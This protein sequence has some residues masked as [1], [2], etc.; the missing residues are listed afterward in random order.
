MNASVLD[1]HRDLL[2][3]MLESLHQ[4]KGAL[5]YPFDTLTMVREN[6]KRPKGRNLLRIRVL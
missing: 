2:R 6:F 5:Q 1:S 3:Q 4:E